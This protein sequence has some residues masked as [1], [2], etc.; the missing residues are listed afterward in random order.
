VFPRDLASFREPVAA[1]AQ[2][3][4]QVFLNHARGDSH[5]RANFVVGHAIAPVQYQHRAA[6]WRQ[7][8]ENGIEPA[9]QSGILRIAFRAA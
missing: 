7:F 2:A 4:A 5:P 1:M 6:F 3:V 9:T 8:A